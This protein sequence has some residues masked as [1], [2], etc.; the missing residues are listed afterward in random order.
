[1]L[2]FNELRFLYC[3]RFYL[4]ELTLKMQVSN[5]VNTVGVCYCYNWCSNSKCPPPISTRA[6]SQTS[7]PLIHC[8][9]DDVVIQVAPLLY[10]S[11]H[12]VVDVMNSWAVDTLLQ[13]DPDLVVNWIEPFSWCKAFINIRSSLLITILLLF[14]QKLRKRWHQYL[15]VKLLAMLATAI[16]DHLFYKKAISQQWT[17]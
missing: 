3:G 6:G 8:R 13:P 16:F 10:Q 12:Q 11:L 15:Q 2:N 4:L 17:G 14:M 1:M 9:T 7:T 5:T